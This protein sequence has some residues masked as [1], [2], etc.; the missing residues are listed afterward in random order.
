MW[1]RTTKI[2]TR[3]GDFDRGAFRLPPPSGL[4]Q[5]V[6]ADFSNATDVGR[7]ISSHG[8]CRSGGL[9]QLV[10]VGEEPAWA[11]GCC[12]RPAPGALALLPSGLCRE[13]LRRHRP[14]ARWWRPSQRRGTRDLPQ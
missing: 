12:S 13:P 11:K 3:D 7:L 9:Y 4:E 10:A 6:A 2:A 1:F 8:G 14:A 5:A